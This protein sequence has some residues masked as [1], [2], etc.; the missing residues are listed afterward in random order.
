[1]KTLAIYDNI[2][3]LIEELEPDMLDGLIPE[4]IEALEHA[5]DFEV[6]HFAVI[7]GKTVAVFDK[8]N[9]DVYAKMKLNDFVLR[10]IEEA[11]NW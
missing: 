11:Q 7:D 4:E 6:T 10:S 9:G 3:T 8:L 5:N 2:H 1:M